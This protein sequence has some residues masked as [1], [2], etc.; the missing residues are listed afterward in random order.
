MV[1][2]KE[3]KDKKINY[4]ELTNEMI[5]CKLIIRNKLV[6]EKRG[7]ERDEESASAW[8]AAA[9]GRKSTSAEIIAKHSLEIQYREKKYYQGDGTGNVTGYL[10]WDGEA[11]AR[12][13]ETVPKGFIFKLL[14]KC[15]I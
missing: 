7:R 10:K 11:E 9:R 5:T 14:I 6:G 1:K 4:K 13:D 3:V 15:M 2:E 12:Y 8:A